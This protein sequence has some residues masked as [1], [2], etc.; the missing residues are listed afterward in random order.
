MFFFIS[1]DIL[2]G[3]LHSVSATAEEAEDD[4]RDYYGEQQSLGGNNNPN[5]VG[6]RNNH[7]AERDID[8]MY[9]TILPHESEVDNYPVTIIK[10]VYGD[11]HIEEDTGFFDE[12]EVWLR[13]SIVY[14]A[15]FN[16]HC[17]VK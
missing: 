8:E 2:T 6:V 14:M 9:Y 16:C 13:V 3:N 11:E 1:N 15:L 7:N 17:Y 4:E 5:S 12:L 10:N